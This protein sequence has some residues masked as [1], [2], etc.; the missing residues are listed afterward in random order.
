MQVFERQY[1]SDLEG[2]QVY[3]AYKYPRRDV[4]AVRPGRA[5]AAARRF[6]PDMM[7]VA[8]D[9]STRRVGPFEMLPGTAAGVAQCLRPGLRSSFSAQLFSKRAGAGMKMPCDTAADWGSYKAHVFRNPVCCADVRIVAQL[10]VEQS[11]QTSPKHAGGVASS[12]ASPA[13]ANFDHTILATE[14]LLRW[15]CNQRV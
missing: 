14:R 8:Y 11:V 7:E 6:L 2:S 15:T 13:A 9:G 4:K 5:V 10:H 3:A 12:Y 1:T